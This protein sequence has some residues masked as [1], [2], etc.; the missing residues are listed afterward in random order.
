MQNKALVAVATA[1]GVS[2]VLAG[3]GL[4]EDAVGG[5]VENGVE[6]AVEQAAGGDIDVDVNSD[7]GAVDLPADLPS[8]IPLPDGAKLTST[9]STPDGWSLSYTADSTA[10]AEGLVARLKSDGWTA[11]YENIVEGMN[12]WSFTNGEYQMV[13]L[14]L[15][16]GTSE[17]ALSLTLVRTPA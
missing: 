15:G 5:A 14:S 9:V 2:L 13:I 12:S 4:V 10:P 7:G 3:C 8:G 11:E 1:L 16:D 6:E 17:Y